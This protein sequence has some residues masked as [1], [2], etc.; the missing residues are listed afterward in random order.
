MRE[1]KRGGEAKTKRDAYPAATQ[2]SKSEG[3]AWVQ[4]VSIASNGAAVQQKDSLK[5]VN[6]VAWKGSRVIYD[7]QREVTDNI[8]PLQQSMQE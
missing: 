2:Q 6:L 5:L 1:K 8:D 7:W 3:H 4:V